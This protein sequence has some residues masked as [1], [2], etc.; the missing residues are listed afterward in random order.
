MMG[1]DLPI[2]SALLDDF[3]RHP[4]GGPNEGVPLAHG[5]AQLCCHAKVSNLDLP[6]LCQQ[7][8]AALD[9]SVHLHHT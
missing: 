4:V 7:N 1:A 9:V 3:W 6:C 2:I 8:V 5:V